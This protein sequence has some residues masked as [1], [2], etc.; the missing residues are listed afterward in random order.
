VVGKPESG[1]HFAQLHRAVRQARLGEAVDAPD[2]V[3]PDLGRVYDELA[4]VAE[5]ASST[6]ALR[7]EL[8]GAVAER[9]ALSAELRRLEAE[10]LQARNSPKVDGAALGEA[11]RVLERS[12]GELEQSLGAQASMGEQASHHLKE[13]INALKEFNE[14]IEVL[15]ARAEESSA[16][17]QGM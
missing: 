16:S 4:R 12:I 15:A 8:A 14:H 17:I 11:S 5:A 3:P 13:M 10:L 2:G 1:E 7:E 6:A 9:Q